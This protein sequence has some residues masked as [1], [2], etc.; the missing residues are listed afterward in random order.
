[1]IAFFERTRE[2]Y[3]MRTVGERYFMG[4]EHAELVASYAMRFLTGTHH[5]D[6]DLVR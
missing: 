3:D 5:L 1:V 6:P 4:D 2:G